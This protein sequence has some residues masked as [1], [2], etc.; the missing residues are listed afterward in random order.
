MVTQGDVENLDSE[1][2][3]AFLRVL[4]RPAEV[5][6]LKEAIV[7]HGVHNLEEASTILKFG[8]VERYMLR[9]MLVDNLEVKANLC[10]KITQ[11][12]EKSN[13][14]CMVSSFDGHQMLGHVHVDECVSGHHGEQCPQR[15]CESDFSG[16]LDPQWRVGCDPL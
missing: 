8:Q 7:S 12:L 14:L 3:Q 5:Q 1:R 2:L 13:E 10:L 6:K 11:C 16:C 15:G 9:F 4:P